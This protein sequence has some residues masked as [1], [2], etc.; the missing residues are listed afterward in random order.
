MAN[1]E[2][3]QKENLDKLKGPYTDITQEYNC[4]TNRFDILINWKQLMT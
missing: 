2:R 4:K 1:A 3:R